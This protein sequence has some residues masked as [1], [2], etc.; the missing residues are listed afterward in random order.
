MLELYTIIV[1]C[2]LQPED[3]T[4]SPVEPDDEVALNRPN[5]LAPPSSSHRPRIGMGQPVQK[6]ARRTRT[7]YLLVVNRIYSPHETFTAQEPLVLV[8]SKSHEMSYI[9]AKF[10]GGV[11]SIEVNQ[12]QWLQST[13][14]SGMPFPGKRVALQS[15]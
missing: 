5:P 15:Q 14:H 3:S 7:C 11:Q 8:L 9:A 6:D 13:K 12:H 2:C 10:F 4:S 1:L